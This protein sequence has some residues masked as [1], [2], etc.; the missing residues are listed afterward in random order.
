[1]AHCSDAGVAFAA[2]AAQWGGGCRRMDLQSLG[3]TIAQQASAAY[4]HVYAMLLKEPLEVDRATQSQ[5][6]H[7]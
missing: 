2:I 1:M 3:Y 5:D 7:E 6:L 4:T